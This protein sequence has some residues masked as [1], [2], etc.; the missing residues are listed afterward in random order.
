MTQPAAGALLAGSPLQPRG[1]LAAEFRELCG[2]LPGGR[3]WPWSVSPQ[4]HCG[5]WGPD[6]RVWSA[7]AVTAP[8]RGWVLHL[9]HAY[10]VHT[11][12]QR[13]HLVDAHVRAVDRAR[14]GEVG[15][16]GMR[17]GRRIR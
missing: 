14:S 12:E 16:G 15:V 5:G 9:V 10:A 3:R 11:G 17:R 1:D 4:P 2:C 13:G 8:H 7:A 6:W